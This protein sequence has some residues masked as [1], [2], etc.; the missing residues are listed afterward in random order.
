MSYRGIIEKYA[1]GQ[2]KRILM[3]A[4]GDVFLSEAAKNNNPKALKARLYLENAEFHAERLAI[5]AMV[6]DPDLTT[7][8]PDSQFRKAI[9][10][11][12]EILQKG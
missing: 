5:L 3:V 9:E 2:I 4:A 11:V 6:K 1:D 12:F 7:N 10:D 8:S